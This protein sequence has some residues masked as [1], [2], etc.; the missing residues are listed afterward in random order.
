MS[1]PVDRGADRRTAERVAVRFVATYRSPHTTAEGLVTDLSRRGLFL[2]GGAHDAIGTRAVV[3][4]RLAD[5]QLTLM[6][7]VA[8]HHDG[9]LGFCFDDLADH[10]RRQIANIVLSA[11]SAR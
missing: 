7:K 2:A 5:R 11:H 8:R 4:V 9:G 10:A 1:A 3:E 6:G